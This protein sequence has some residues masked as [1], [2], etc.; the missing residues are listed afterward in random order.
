MLDII[1]TII[2]YIV[3]S[4]QIPALHCQ[5]SRIQAYNACKC[6]LFPA[7]LSTVPF[8]L[9]QVYIAGGGK[10]P[11][12]IQA[13]LAQISTQQRSD[14][15]TPPLPSSSHSREAGDALGRAALSSCEDDVLCE[16][17]EVTLLMREINCSNQSRNQGR[18]Q[19]WGPEYMVLTKALSEISL[20]QKIEL[21]LSQRVRMIAS[22]MMLPELHKEQPE[23]FRH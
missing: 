1:T 2:D 3:H 18:K 21:W 9:P 14:I 16:M 13:V 7:A 12:S 8:L 23:Q 10:V 17:V 6:P 15:P 4:L 20:G 22:V 5:L 19:Q 11:A